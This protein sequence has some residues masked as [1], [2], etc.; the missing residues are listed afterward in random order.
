MAEF[1]MTDLGTVSF[2]LGIQVSQ[3]F[4]PS[5]IVFHQQHYIQKL[6]E[7]FNLSN[8]KAVPTPVAS[9][10]SL[11]KHQCPT[12]EEEIEAMR[13]VTYRTLVGC[14]LWVSS[15]TRPDVSYVT[16]QVSQFLANPGQTHWVAAKWVLRYLKGTSDLGITYS[17]QASA[18]HQLRIQ[19]WSDSNWASDL[20]TRRSITTFCLLMADSV[21]TCSSKKRSTVAL[22]STEAKYAAVVSASQEIMHVRALL[23]SLGYEQLEPTVLRC[24]N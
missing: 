23:K 3:S 24:D 9:G 7:K 1:S 18:K 14:L 19:A 10:Q 22:L 2:F 17:A 13:D 12:L 6:L 16:P 21:I 11:T 4:N 15:W 8:A 20:D 5:R